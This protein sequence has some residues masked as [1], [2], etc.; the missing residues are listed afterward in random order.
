MKGRIVEETV[1]ESVLSWTHDQGF[2]VKRILV[3]EADNLVITPYK[4]E[5]YVANGFDDSNAK[6]IKEIEIPDELVQKALEFVRMKDEFDNLEGQF[7]ALT[8]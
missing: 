2:D 6:L 4:G 5:I 3:P 7:R 1:H 8:R